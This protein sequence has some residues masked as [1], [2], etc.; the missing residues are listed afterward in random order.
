MHL[1]KNGC[2]SYIFW[3]IPKVDTDSDSFVNNLQ[4]SSSFLYDL[5]IGFISIQLG[6]LG[7]LIIIKS[8]LQGSQFWIPVIP[9]FYSLN[10]N[11]DIKTEEGSLIDEIASYQNLYQL[12]TKDLQKCCHKVVDPEDAQ[13][14]SWSRKSFL[15]H[16]LGF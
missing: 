5:A 2:R 10:C 7:S 4:L 9:V 6:S 11:S 13:K 16:F 1:Y 15:G 14:C 8:L 12:L 3:T